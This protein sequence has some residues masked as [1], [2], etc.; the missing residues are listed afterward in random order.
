LSI[1]AEKEVGHDKVRY[2]V[3]LTGT[4]NLGQLK[5][6]VEDYSSR[7]SK[8]R[9]GPYADEFKVIQTFSQPEDAAVAVDNYNE[10][11]ERIKT[12]QEKQKP[13]NRSPTFTELFQGYKDKK[14]VQ[15]FRP[16]KLI[17]GKKTDRSA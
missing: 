11:R 5:S 15:E 4:A 6:A 14:N 17:P 16:E 8:A 3:S 13:A 9:G 10:A 12:G 1:S 7:L 2:A